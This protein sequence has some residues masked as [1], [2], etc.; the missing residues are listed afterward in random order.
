M[1]TLNI[2]FFIYYI[3]NNDENNNNIL[4]LSKDLDS[5][6]IQNNNN[7]IDKDKIKGDDNNDM[8]IT[9]VKYIEER[10]ID[11]EE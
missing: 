2:I 6:L 4:G 10:F 11:D 1:D 9:L 8:K 3:I 7:I 5:P